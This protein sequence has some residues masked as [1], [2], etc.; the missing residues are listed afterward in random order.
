MTSIQQDPAENARAALLRL[1]PHLLGRVRR[2]VVGSS[3]YAQKLRAAI[4]NAARPIPIGT[5]GECEEC[6]EHHVRL[7]GGVCPLCRDGR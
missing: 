5:P 3:R 6:G 2:G 1:A 4:R 7:V